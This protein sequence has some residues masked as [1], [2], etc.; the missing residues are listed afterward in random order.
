MRLKTVRFFSRAQGWLLLL[1]MLAMQASFSHS[2]DR[3]WFVTT[4]IGTPP[5]TTL[6]NILTFG[7]QRL[8]AYGMMLY[9]QS[10]DAQAGQA[11]KIRSLD[12]NASQNWFEAAM[13]IAPQQ[14]Y[15]LFLAARIYA[16]SAP[17]QV[18]ADMLEMVYRH[19]FAAPNERWPWLAHAAYIA[20]HEMQD[21]ALAARF[22][23]A[24]R[25]YAT[26]ESVP[27]WA[28]D[29]EI[30]ILA[31]T[32]QLEAAHL[33]LGALIDSGQ[34]TDQRELHAMTERL[35]QLKTRMAADQASKTDDTRR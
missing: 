16:E 35:T 28:R 24:I 15:P 29:L 2:H 17:P 13:R 19:F 20:R 30:F 10:F 21:P 6:L 7:E 23:R 27:R 4:S 34:L 9:L 14:A 22:A 26:A 31:S 1:A 18:R 33:L 32:D 5:N 8:A 3:R 11:I 12:Q 25:E